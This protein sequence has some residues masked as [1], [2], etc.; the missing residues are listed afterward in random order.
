MPI[1]TRNTSTCH[2]WMGT[3]AW[4]LKPFS[5]CPLQQC[6]LPHMAT[7]DSSTG[8]DFSGMTHMHAGHTPRSS[9]SYASVSCTAG[10]DGLLGSS[11]LA[12]TPGASSLKYDAL[13][14][15][16]TY[17]SRRGRCACMA[18][19]PVQVAEVLVPGS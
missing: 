15:R 12:D 11:Q 6:S 10:A 19:K 17:V 8:T 18:S 5:Q 9:P 4:H 13:T 1:T 7:D 14:K 3:H 16:Y 2:A